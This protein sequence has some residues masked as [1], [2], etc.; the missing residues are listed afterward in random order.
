ML[1]TAATDLLRNPLV[2]YLDTHTHVYVCVC[3]CVVMMLWQ[4]AVHILQEQT[5]RPWSGVSH[6][7]QTPII[8]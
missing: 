2:I 8:F 3:M 7:D 4:H 5:Q 1:D 6:V